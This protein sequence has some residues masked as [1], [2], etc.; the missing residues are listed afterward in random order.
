MFFPFF[1]LFIVLAVD[2]YALSKHDKIKLIND[3][4]ILCSTHKKNINFDN[5]YLYKS[6][7][8]LRSSIENHN[9]QKYHVLNTQHKQQHQQHNN[10]HYEYQ[11]STEWCAENDL[12]KFEINLHKKNKTYHDLFQYKNIKSYRKRYDR[13]LQYLKYGWYE[14][15]SVGFPGSEMNRYTNNDNITSVP[16][17]CWFDIIQDISHSTP[18][19]HYNDKMQSYVIWINIG[20]KLLTYKHQYRNYYHYLHSSS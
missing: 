15:Y 9:Q 4:M 3:S 10:H 2:N 19:H 14:G 18:H 20:E 17:G 13:Y 16:Y 11:Q 7:T 6:N 1:S 12:F 5:K 8:K